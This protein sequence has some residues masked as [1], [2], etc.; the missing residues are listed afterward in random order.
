MTA[1]RDECRTSSTDILPR[2]RNLVLCRKSREMRSMF[3][4]L[5]ACFAAAEHGSA[6]VEMAVV[7]PVVLLLMTGIF[8]FSMALYQKLELAEAVSSGGRFLAV[9]RGDTDP[10]ATTAAK[11]YAAA[12]TLNSSNVTL[13][14]VL[15]GTSY[16]GA[17]CSGTTNMVSGGSAQ[18]TATYPCSLSVFGKGYSSCSL[19]E[20]VTEVVQ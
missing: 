12:P 2:N 9:D 13:T 17:T 7:M 19:G 6:L 5:R 3:A 16:P 10:C 11:V 4:R 20:Q 15:N 18:L 14:F 8:T 1:S